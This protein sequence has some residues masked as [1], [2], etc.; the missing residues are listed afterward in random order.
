M[1]GHIPPL[2][3]LLF[4]FSLFCSALS[5]GLTDAQINIVKQRL[6]EGATHRSAPYLI[7]FLSSW[8]PLGHH[9]FARMLPSEPSGILILKRAAAKAPPFT[10]PIPLKLTIY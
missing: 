3:S 1:H 9:P 5:Q 10:H 7:P 6:Q 2:E 8:R 4:L